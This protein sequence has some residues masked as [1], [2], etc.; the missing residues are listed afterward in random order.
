MN[1]LIEFPLE[2]SVVVEVD[3]PEAEGGV[4]RAGRLGEVSERA[5]LSFEEAL[6]KLRPV[7]ERIIARLRALSDPPDQVG[8]EFGVKLG[9]GACAVITSS[10]AEANYRIALTWKRS[11]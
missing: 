11:D 8:V 3:E 7:A 5:Q 10:A 6:G 1:R 2:G 9:S 4:V